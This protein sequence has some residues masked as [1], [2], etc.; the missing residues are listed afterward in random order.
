MAPP[1]L[2]RCMVVSLSAER[3]RLIRTAAE[4]QAWDAFVCRDAGEFLRAAFKR[5]VPLIVVDLPD[6]GSP[7]YRELQGVVER[8]KEITDSLML[9]VGPG[10]DAREEIWARQ[11]G[12]WV[13]ACEASSSG[14]LELLF[15]EA[16]QAV[17]RREILNPTLRLTDFEL[18]ADHSTSDA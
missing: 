11:L 4:A 15:H 6:S 14:G 13:Y 9:V 2:L 1:Q 18:E 16:R 10:V 7:A 8:A 12:A 17:E 3:R 5:S